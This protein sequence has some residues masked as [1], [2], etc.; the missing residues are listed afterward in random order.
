MCYGYE[1]LTQYETMYTTSF[2]LCS[3]EIWKRN[4]ISSNLAFRCTIQLKF[5]RLLK[6]IKHNVNIENVPH[7]QSGG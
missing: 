5:V 6:L 7:F 2:N 1:Y 4:P 3:K